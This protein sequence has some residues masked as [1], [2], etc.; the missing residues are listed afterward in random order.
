MNV[1]EEA[2]AFK[3]RLVLVLFVLKDDQIVNKGR[4]LIFNLLVR[5][6]VN[7]RKGSELDGV[8]GYYLIIDLTFEF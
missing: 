3:P 6:S 5:S 1:T 8:M 7:G 4:S 2:Y